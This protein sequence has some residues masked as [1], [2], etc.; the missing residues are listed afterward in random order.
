MIDSNQPVWH[1]V[2]ETAKQLLW[3]TQQSIE[4]TQDGV[5]NKQTKNIE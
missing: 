1:R 3:R 5:E 4:F 2:L